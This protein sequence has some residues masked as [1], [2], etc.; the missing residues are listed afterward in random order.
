LD[1]STLLDFF[2]HPPKHLHL[3]LLGGFGFFFCMKPLRG[4]AVIGGGTLFVPLDILSGDFLSA[5]GHNVFFSTH[6][7]LSPEQKGMVGDASRLAFRVFFL[8]EARG[9]LSS[10][11]VVTY[12]NG[13]GGIVGPPP[14][15]F[16]EGSFPIWEKTPIPTGPRKKKREQ[17]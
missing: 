10:L 16:G 9:L 17:Y 13:R 14:L 7:L 3:G 5:S 1:T 6:V 15:S 2:S 12:S 11:C 8:Y 4:P